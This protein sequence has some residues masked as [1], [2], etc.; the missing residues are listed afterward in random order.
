MLNDRDGKSLVETETAIR[1]LLDSVVHNDWATSQASWGIDWLL[2]KNPEGVWK[3]SKLLSGAYG[4]QPRPTRTSVAKPQAAPFVLWHD[5]LPPRV[6][7]ETP[8]VIPTE[9]VRGEWWRG[10]KEL[11]TLADKPVDPL[12][13]RPEDA[14]THPVE[15][16]TADELYRLCEVPVCRWFRRQLSHPS[17]VFQATQVD[18]AY[19]IT[20]ARVCASKAPEARRAAFAA[21]VANQTPE[22]WRKMASKSQGALSRIDMWLAMT[23]D[24]AKERF[25]G[26]PYKVGS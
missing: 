21:M 3:A 2:T 26:K 15:W 12:P 5:P 4:N 24:G 10:R 23:Q 1:A 9:I 14:A 19:A 13:L 6:V 22:V 25:G 18:L 7:I 17:P 11:E 8:I 20:A 16:L